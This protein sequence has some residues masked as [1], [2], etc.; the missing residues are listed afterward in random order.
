MQL[1][2]A[3]GV[4]LTLFFWVFLGAAIG[5]VVELS[6]DDKKP[7][8]LLRA[9]LGAEKSVVLHILIY[10]INI[11]AGS[12]FAYVATPFILDYLKI[13]ATRT[14]ATGFLVGVVGL[15]LLNGFASTWRSRKRVTDL[16]F[17]FIDMIRSTKP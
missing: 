17:K 13:E 7:S 8:I 5:L 11:L 12:L 15:S 10:T 2:D 14:H 16:I 6:T 9:K 4:E 1:L 3:I